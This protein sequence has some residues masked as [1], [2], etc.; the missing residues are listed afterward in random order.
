MNPQASTEDR[1][2][3]AAIDG[4]I[5]FGLATL[6]CGIGLLALMDRI[7]VPEGLVRALALIFVIFGLAT[8]A[9][10]FRGMRVS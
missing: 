1:L 8:I 9:A 10:L 3:R 4:R 6:L 5:A 7:G 2:H